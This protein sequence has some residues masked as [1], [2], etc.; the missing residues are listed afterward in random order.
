MDNFNYWKRHRSLRQIFNLA[1]TN[2]KH[3]R[4]YICVVSK[5]LNHYVNMRLGTGQQERGY[6]SIPFVSTES[7]DSVTRTM[8]NDIITHHLHA[9][10]LTE[11]RKPSWSL[12]SSHECTCSFPASQGCTPYLLDYPLVEQNKLCTETY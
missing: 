7:F 3:L 6:R 2:L 10:A 12:F 9:M 8:R 1:I 11:S 4:E 5:I